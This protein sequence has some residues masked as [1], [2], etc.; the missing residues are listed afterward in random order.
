[1]QFFN[2]MGSHYFDE[3]DQH[4]FE[5]KQACL[6]PNTYLDPA[7]IRRFLWPGHSQRHDVRQ[8]VLIDG[9]TQHRSRG[10][11]NKY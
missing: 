6:T 11:F 7:V 10:T 9:S 3:K 1:M 8:G 4:V 2:K 5:V